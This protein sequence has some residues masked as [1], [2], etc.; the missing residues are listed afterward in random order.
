[1]AVDHVDDLQFSV[2]QLLRRRRTAIFHD[3]DIEALIGKAPHG[4]GDA[5][6]GKNASRDHVA[7]AHI[8][9]DE[10]KVGAGQGAVG[11]LR[12]DDFV[13]LRGQG[14]DDLR[15]M[16][17]LGKKEIVPA[18]FLLTER[19]VAAVFGERRDTRESPECRICGKKQSDAQH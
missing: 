6:V 16:G 12:D 5:L 7:D 19:T 11:G 10:A 14:G 1:M 18:G 17:V 9:K 4:R 3:N 8:A 13:L 2:V 15:R